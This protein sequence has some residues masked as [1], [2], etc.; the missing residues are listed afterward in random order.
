MYLKNRV[1]NPRAARTASTSG[2]ETPAKIKFHQNFA[3]ASNR[4]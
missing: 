4:D 2:H 1:E 3:A